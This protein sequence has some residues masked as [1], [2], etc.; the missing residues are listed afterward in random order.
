[1][2]LAAGRVEFG[3]HR[4]RRVVNILAG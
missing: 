4:G 2:A 1:F 3:T